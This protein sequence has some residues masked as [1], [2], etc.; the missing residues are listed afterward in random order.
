MHPQNH[1]RPSHPALRKSWD[2]LHLASRDGILSSSQMTRLQRERLT[3]AGFLTPV[4]RGWYRLKTASRTPEAQPNILNFLPVYLEDRLGDRWCLSAESSLIAKYAPA[5][6]QNRLVVLSDVSSTTVHTFDCGFRLTIYQDDQQLPT[7]MD[8]LEGWQVMPVDMILA[9]L[10]QAQWQRQLHLVAQILPSIE[11]W[12]SITWQMLSEERYQSTT[13][14]AER[15]L[16]TNNIQAAK[17]VINGLKSAG[18]SIE[19]P[20]S[21][22]VSQP[23]S[24]FKIELNPVTANDV[25]GDATPNKTEIPLE[26][27]W[28]AWSEKLPEPDFTPSSLTD[29]ILQRLSLI[30]FCL[31]DDAQNHLALSGYIAPRGAIM[32]D[33]AGP[34]MAANIN[35]W[36]HLSSE[37]RKKLPEG[38]LPLPGEMDPQALVAMNGYLEALRQAKRSIVRLMEGT[39]LQRVLRQDVRG[40][41]LALMG[42]SA[43]AGLISKRQILRYRKDVPEKETREKMETLGQLIA[44][45]PNIQYRGLL[46]FLSIMTLKPWDTGNQRMALLTMNALNSAAG[47]PWTIIPSK[48]A[49]ELKT[50]LD[51]AMKT[52]DPYPALHLMNKNWVI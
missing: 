25:E 29:N 40:W 32:A 33:L 23:I 49:D 1:E 48:N 21:S 13:R 16:E 30:E 27:Q 6:H 28:E 34:E 3:A 39:D 17:V 7:R 26:A 11:E 18:I 41:R 46:S 19:K 43:E 44:Q 24:A 8:Q 10:T 4:M 47:L 38:P 35:N 36:P 12:D 37:E 31:P 50:A 52:K 5:Q 51:V 15:L 9:R 20:V 14:L 45:C 22:T 42:P 2:K